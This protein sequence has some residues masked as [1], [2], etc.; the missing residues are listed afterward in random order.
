MSPPGM[1]RLISGR[2]SCLNHTIRHEMSIASDEGLLAQVPDGHV[3][4]YCGSRWGPRKDAYFWNAN[5]W[6]VD[7][8]EDLRMFLDEVAEIS[9][10][11]CGLGDDI[12]T[13]WHNLLPGQMHEAM[14]SNSTVFLA[15][16]WLMAVYHI[17]W[18]NRLPY[19]STTDYLTGDNIEEPPFCLICKL[20]VDIVQASNDALAILIESS[21]DFTWDR[22]KQRYVPFSVPP[23]LADAA[24]TPAAARVKGLANRLGDLIFEA[25]NFLRA[26]S[27][28]SA[29]FGGGTCDRYVKAERDV[30]ELA[31]G[32]SSDLEFGLEKPGVF[33]TRLRSALAELNEATSALLTFDH[34]IEDRRAHCGDMIDRA[35]HAITPL[36]GFMD[37]LKTI[38]V[39]SQDSAISPAEKILSAETVP[40][41]TVAGPVPG[42][43]A[44]ERW[45]TV[46]DA[47]RLLLDVISNIDMK[48]AKARVSRA[49][50]DKKFRTNGMKG[51]GRRIDLDSF[52]TWRFEM[53]DRDLAAEDCDEPATS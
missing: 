26:W 1:L 15:D 17:A 33:E 44:K 20:P 24:V 22:Q 8:D 29:N 6:H 36:R 35:W 32:I 53:R 51:R 37:S 11:I 25:G 45:L 21:G 39:R 5:N 42:S 12:P 46:T 43:V 48:K 14:G 34:I 10:V 16:Y 19:R 7:G 50:E 41:E 52:N 27:G 3:S 28:G 9:K 49:A 47:A 4:R 31:K 30:E 40:Q 23:R 13:A 38:A 18:A 2:L